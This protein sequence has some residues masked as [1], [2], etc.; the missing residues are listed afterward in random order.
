MTTTVWDAKTS[1]SASPPPHF[2]LN[3]LLPEFCRAGT[4][5]LRVDLR[6]TKYSKIMSFDMHVGKN[7][8]LVLAPRVGDLQVTTA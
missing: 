4:L 7:V 5:P 6:W 3:A 1:A 8:G 2:H